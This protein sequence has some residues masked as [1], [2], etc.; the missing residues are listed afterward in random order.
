[1]ACGTPLVCSPWNDAEGLFTAGKDFLMAA[2]PEE[3]KRHLRTVVLDA[4]AAREISM[5]GLKTIR[6]RH[7]C[8]HRVDELL[9]IVNELKGGREC[10]LLSLDPA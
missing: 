9:Q 3:M 7:T 8:A 5:N 6:E 2:T 10:T 4:A 1:L